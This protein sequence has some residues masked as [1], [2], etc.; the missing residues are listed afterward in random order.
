MVPKYF[1]S[2]GAELRLGWRIREPEDQGALVQKEYESF[3]GMY[4][5]PIRYALT[6]GELA[7]FVHNSEAMS[8]ELHTV[9]V[10]NWTRGMLFNE[11]DQTL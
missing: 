8:Y 9:P 1:N 4:P 11:T 3:V 7:R 5:L 6:A 10:K 2:I